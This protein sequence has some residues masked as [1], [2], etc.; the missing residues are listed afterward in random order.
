MYELWIH[1]TKE[2]VSNV[3]ATM[4]IKHIST[5][6]QEDNREFR[7]NVTGDNVALEEQIRTG[8]DDNKVVTL[9]EIV[10]EGV[11]RYGSGNISKLKHEIEC[12]LYNGGNNC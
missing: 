9:T 5:T 3:P 12:N 4:T 7:V 1:T 10:Q 6:L 8:S 2:D 11:P